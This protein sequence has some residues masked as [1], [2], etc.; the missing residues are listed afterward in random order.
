MFVF[1]AAAILSVTAAANV[2]AFSAVT[3]VVFAKIAVVGSFLADAIFV[4][5]AVAFAV[6]FSAVTAVVFCYGCCCCFYGCFIRVFWFSS[7]VS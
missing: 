1:L 6:A 4:V 7:S 3:A 5:A 2:A